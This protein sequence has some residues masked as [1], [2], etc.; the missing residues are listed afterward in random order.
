MACLALFRCDFLLP[1]Y[2]LIMIELL[3]NNNNN[4]ILHVI[5]YYILYILYIYYII[6]IIITIIIILS[7]ETFD[8]QFAFRKHK[9]CVPRHTSWEALIAY[10]LLP[11]SAPN[12]WSPW[13]CV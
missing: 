7:L 2:S 1:L 10:E 8:F 12:T 5:L 3:V 4:Y 6:I 11:T 13:L 9:L